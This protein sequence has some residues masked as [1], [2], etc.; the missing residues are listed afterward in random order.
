MLWTFSIKVLGPSSPSA[1]QSI[2]F[3]YH[4]LIF[5]SYSKNM[6]NC[7][8]YHI[9]YDKSNMI[10]FW[11]YDKFQYDKDFQCLKNMIK[12]KNMWILGLC[13]NFKRDLV[14]KSILQTSEEIFCL[15]MGRCIGSFTTCAVGRVLANS[16]REIIF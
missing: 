2:G 12:C 11:K 5:L 3:F 10:I 8:F 4:I 6:I 16:F 14:A 1:P 9:L 7:N 13:I 15:F